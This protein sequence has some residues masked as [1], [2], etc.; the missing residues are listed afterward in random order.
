MTDGESR[1]YGLMLYPLSDDRFFIRATVFDSEFLGSTPVQPGN[2]PFQANG[3]AVPNTT[4]PITINGTGGAIATGLNALVT[5]GRLTAAQADAYRVGPT[6][7]SIDV[8]SKGY[9][10]EFIANPTKKLTL[11]AGFSY[12]ERD[13]A[14]FLKEQ[15]PYVPNLKAFLA[16]VN[17]SGVLITNSA[18]G[19]TSTATDY[20]TEAIDEF[21]EVTGA[22]QEQSFGSRPYKFNLTSRY[23]FTDGF[24]KGFNVGGGV[25]WQSDN[26]MQ[27]D[28]R[29]LVDGIANP[30][31]GK[32]YYGNA[33]EM[34]D[35]FTTY[36]RRLPWLKNP[37]TFQV[38]VRNAFN[39][40]RVLPARYVAD[41]SAMR[42]V[43]LNEPRSIR[44]SMEVEF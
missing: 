27:K 10:I 44:F 2:H 29:E 4:T 8:V 12:S 11:R 37:V 20:I 30:N 43:T 38:N 6:A 32:E 14:N 19:I 42:R 15:N 36:K 33:F 26:Y 1:D 39:Q 23:R 41:F 13:R 31:F 28:L 34:W 22:N 21:I 40:S 18:T 35:F 24:L 17:S 25:R 7:F 16:T 3:T 9:E 5:Y